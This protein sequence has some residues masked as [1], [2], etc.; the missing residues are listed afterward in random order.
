MS[1]AK[2]ARSKMKRWGKESP[3]QRDR[4]VPGRALAYTAGGSILVGSI[5]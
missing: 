3:V 4:D 5:M 2:K 1:C